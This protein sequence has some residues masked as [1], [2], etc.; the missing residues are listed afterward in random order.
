MTIVHVENY[1]F[2]FH[3]AIG[4]SVKRGLCHTCVRIP[5]FLKLVT[6][7]RVLRTTSA[8]ADLRMRVVSCRELLGQLYLIPEYGDVSCFPKFWFPIFSCF[9]IFTLSLGWFCAVCVVLAAL[10]VPL[11]VTWLTVYRPLRRP[12]QV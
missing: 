2:G 3:L 10:R 8:P 4:N 7:R 6:W 1:L 12:E 11:A 9:P 5:R